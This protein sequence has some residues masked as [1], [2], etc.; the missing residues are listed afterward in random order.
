VSRAEPGRRHQHVAREA[1]TQSRLELGLDVSDDPDLGRL[2]PEPEQR[3]GEERPVEI[4]P[5]AADE[6]RAGEDDRGA[7]RCA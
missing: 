4:P 1:G 5:V 3:S 7:Q 6:L 2:D